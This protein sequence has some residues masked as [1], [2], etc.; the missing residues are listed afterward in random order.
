MQ[1]N[2][3]THIITTTLHS[4]LTLSTIGQTQASL[5]TYLILQC[6]LSSV[7][8]LALCISYSISEKEIARKKSK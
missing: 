3:P 7:T 6:P 1:H 4:F 2:P 8:K 5:K